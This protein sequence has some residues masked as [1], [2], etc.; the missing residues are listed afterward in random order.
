MCIDCLCLLPC[1]MGSANVQEWGRR[2]SLPPSHSTFVFTQ[3][4]NV[5]SIKELVAGASRLLTNIWMSHCQAAGGQVRHWHAYQ[6]V[7]GSFVGVLQQNWVL[8][9]VHN[10]LPAVIGWQAAPV[11]YW[12]VTHLAESSTEGCC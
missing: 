9:R 5:H 2:N 11:V 1:S 4:Q 12:P 10:M 8:K 7:Q 3:Q 6:A